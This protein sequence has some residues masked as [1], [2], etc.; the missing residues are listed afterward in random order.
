MSALS[1][2]ARHGYFELETPNASVIQTD[3]EHVSLTILSCVCNIRQVEH[4]TPRQIREKDE[5]RN[6]NLSLRAVYNL[7]SALVKDR[8]YRIL[9]AGSFIY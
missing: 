9:L 1:T 7:L 2:L 3:S 6:L 4:R 8:E 5:H